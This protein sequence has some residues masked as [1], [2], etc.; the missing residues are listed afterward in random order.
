[1][2]AIPSYHFLKL[3]WLVIPGT[4]DFP[5]TSLTTLLELPFLGNS[6]SHPLLFYIIQSLWTISST[7][8]HSSNFHQSTI[9]Q[10]CHSST[11]TDL[12]NISAQ[13][14]HRFQIE[15]ILQA[16]SFIWPQYGIYIHS[17]FLTYFEKLSQTV[18]SL[19]HNLSPSPIHITS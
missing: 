6:L 17:V 19:Y 4:R 18:S 15:F 9:F 11:D 8:C 12:L 7:P 2:L 3:N 16:K 13:M 14:I 10:T 1:M 5:C